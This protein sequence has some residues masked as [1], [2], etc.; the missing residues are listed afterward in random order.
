MSTPL[1][2]CMFARSTIDLPADRW[3]AAIVYVPRGDAKVHMRGSE[4]PVT[5][6]PDNGDICVVNAGEKS[7]LAA[8]PSALAIVFRLDVRQVRRMINDRAVWFVCNPALRHQERYG[9][10]RHYLQAYVRTLSETGD[11]VEL[12]RNAAEL[13]I[14]QC[15]LDGYT[16]GAEQLQ[17]RAERFCSFVDAHYD[18]PISLA[19][20]ARHF[21]FSPEYMAKVFKREVG[22][23]LLG[24]L[25]SVRLDVACAQL[26]QT[27]DTVTRIALEA[28]FP[29]VASFNQ[30]FRRAYGMTPSKYRKQRA[31]KSGSISLQ[32]PDATIELATA[33]SELHADAR[34]LVIDLD[35]K[36]TSFRPW[37]DMLGVGSIEALGQ[38]R[39]REQVRSLHKRLRFS[40]G[41]VSCDF[42]Q[43]QTARDIYQL[44]DCF[45]FLLTTGIVPHVTMPVTS[46]VDVRS[47]VDTVI[48]TLR[49]FINRYSL[50][51]VR[52]WRFELRARM[53]LQPYDPLFL[54]LFESLS[55]S[56]PT[57]GLD[58]LLCGPGC[59][60][61]AEAANLREFLRAAH[62]R[63]IAL[64]GVTMAVRPH[65]A[66][67]PDGGMV[68][69]ADRRAMRS[70]LMTARE[71]LVAEGW[72]PQLLM[73]GGW[74][75]TLELH[76]V[77]N[78]TCFEAANICQQLLS[79]QDL[80]STICYDWALDAIC[81]AANERP[82]NHLLSGKP[83]LLTRDGIPKPSLLAF[84]FLGNIG[85]RVVFSSGECV[86]S[87]NEMG[88]LQ[89]VSHNCERLGAR[90]LA[91]SE[92]DLLYEEMA[93]YFENP[94][95][96]KL[97]VRI[98]GAK[99]GTYL[100]KKR[101][102]NAEGGSV[103]D[104]AARMRLW[105]ADNPGRSEVEYLRAC[106]QPQ[107]Q[108][109]VV[110]CTDG[111]IAFSHELASNEVAYFHVIY[112]Y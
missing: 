38:A 54:E 81:P 37:C 44:E 65:V 33:E 24:Y 48:Q 68:R 18:E 35:N 31:K 53:G 19:E 67:A 92:E 14:V 46:E 110:L 43:Y 62:A 104:A 32:V 12:H 23:T 89:I 87:V 73:V 94:G 72:N 107:M 103:A 4:A 21:G 91:T 45:D 11:F 3:H 34:D 49:L 83:G 90:Y 97:D 102:V 39:V 99:P 22:Q 75:D 55:A 51:T 111:I 29:N 96:R 36:A 108:L 1:I 101:F 84:E 13:A 52:S 42:E 16:G 47:Y 109:E 98:C 50:D 57:V 7:T 59:T 79:C 28:G 27:N 100:V 76:N 20:V 9:G 17:T 74:S 15:L 40:Y 71:V 70:Q 8:S 112:L 95:P 66:A 86:A 80:T 77:M 30:A 25:T 85:E 2:S 64:G 58:V 6:S 5:L 26:L 88:N 105:C 106:A 82:T 56:L 41:R 60:L 10:L 93:S 61:S 78:D 63:G 69:T